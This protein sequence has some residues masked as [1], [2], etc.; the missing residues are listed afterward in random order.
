[1][2]KTIILC[3]ALVLCASLLAGC[4]I[5]GLPFKKAEQPT[6]EAAVDVE[7]VGGV[8]V[9][10]EEIEVEEEPA[11]E[12]KKPKATSDD[13]KLYAFTLANGHKYVVDEYG[14]F[15]ETYTFDADGNLVDM[16]GSWIVMEENVK[17]YKPIRVMYF[18]Q[19][20]YALTAEAS[21][22]TTD[23][24]EQIYSNCVVELYCAPAS[25][26]NG[27]VCIRGDST[28][29]VEI[30]PNSNAKVVNSANLNLME[31][32]V[33]IKADD[34]SLPMTVFVR[35]L[36]NAVTNGEANIIART[37][38]NTAEAEC[39]VTV[40][41]TEARQRR[42]TT[43]GTAA[44][45]HVGTVTPTPSPTPIIQ[46]ISG[47]NEFVNASGDPAKHIHTYTRTVIAPT[48]TSQ[49]YTLYTCTGCGHSYRDNYTSKLAPSE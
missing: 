42:A 1:M 44:T 21:S 36:T 40:E 6:I 28:A 14:R 24:S 46:P 26:T 11:I 7:E 47:A 19:E 15:S 8:E 39:A 23:S 33:A 37:V 31:G 48:E 20:I 17:T 29:V 45:G 22:A 34:L 10:L 35:V 30:R 38:D 4:T 49:G 5:P 32:E 9:D 12:R 25:A 2:K 27:V 41:L 13:V 43:S 18:G 3:V 16:D